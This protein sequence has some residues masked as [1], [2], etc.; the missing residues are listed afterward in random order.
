[1]NDRRLVGIELGIASA[2]SVRVLNGEGDSIGELPTMRSLTDVETAASAGTRLE[3][4]IEPTGPAWLPTAVFIV[5]G[6]L[7]SCFASRSI[8]G[9]V[10][11]ATSSDSA[12]PQ[13]SRVRENQPLTSQCCRYPFSARDVRGRTTT[14]S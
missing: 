6:H 8:A 13:Y 4:V 14:G 2:G 5:R 12:S 1:M 7:V 11:V 9:V 10:A 3:V